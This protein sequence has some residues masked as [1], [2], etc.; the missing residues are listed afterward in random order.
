MP[1]QVIV[2]LHA[3]P[4]AR[5]ELKSVLE[6][7]SATYGPSATGFLGSTVHEML[8]DPEGLVEIADWE[9]AEAQ[10]VAVQ[11]AADSGVYTP[12]L[13]LVAEPIKATRIG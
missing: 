6:G 8:D 13:A 4:G 9:S 7:I 2:E 12:V 3:R 5:A 10:A 1:I 11:R